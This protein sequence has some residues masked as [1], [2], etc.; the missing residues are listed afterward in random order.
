M[1]IRT[2]IEIAA[3][4]E[5]VFEASI[6]LESWAKHIE[7]ITKI[8]ILTPG[9]IGIGTRFVETRMMFGRE[10]SEEMTISELVAPERFVLTAENHGT[11]Y[12]SQHL[13]EPQGD[14]TKLTFAFSGVPVTFL[15]RLFAPLGRV[16]MPSVVK[17]I[18]GDLRD[19]KKAIES[20]EH[21]QTAS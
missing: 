21:Q 12:V 15:A 5:V 11:R 9:P 4:P 1:E 8:E 7:A 14:G 10:A 16:M 20:G 6:D 2:D 19:L 18:E 13:F 17:A 3:P